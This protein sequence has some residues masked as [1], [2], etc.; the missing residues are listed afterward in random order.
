M[1]AAKVEQTT[2]VHAFKCILDAYPLELRLVLACLSRS[3]SSLAL[4]AQDQPTPNWADFLRWVERQRVGP[5]IY[6]SISNLPESFF[7]AEVLRELRARH[8][9]NSLAALGL[10]SETVRVIRLLQSEGIAVMALKGPALA[11]QL[12]GDPASR[13][14]GD[15]D[16]LVSLDDVPRADRI[17]RAAGLKRLQPGFDLSPGQQ[18]RYFQLKYDYEYE[19]PHTGLMVELHWRLDR[20]L[21]MLPLSFEDLAPRASMV[22]L[23]G[24]DVPCL[25]FNDQAVFLLVHGARHGWSKL[26]HLCDIGQMLH[27]RPNQDTWTEILGQARRLGVARPAAQG[28]ILAHLLL[29]TTLP[30]AAREYA[31][32]DRTVDYLVKTALRRVALPRDYPLPLSRF[33]QWEILYHF[34]LRRGWREKIETMRAIFINPDDW[35]QVPLP[36]SL[37]P[38]YYFLRPVLYLQRRLKIK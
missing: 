30:D 8:R 6:S 32:G 16:L 13:S 3:R 29:Q 20:T 15:M 24:Q 11:Q 4:V 22:P 19:K 5:R 25:S 26:F 7:P 12:F 21:G 14:A 2:N 9:R 1:S 18:A 23:G 33:L 36:D 38:L 17:L 35:A 27:L 28:L 10:A 34:M 31:A 37:F